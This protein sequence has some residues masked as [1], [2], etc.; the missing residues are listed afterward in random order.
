MV[1]LFGKLPETL[2]HPQD[3]PRRSFDVMGF[4]LRDGRKATASVVYSYGPDCAA[5]APLLRLTRL[6]S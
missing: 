4:R 2:L 1:G 6:A 5:V 3:P